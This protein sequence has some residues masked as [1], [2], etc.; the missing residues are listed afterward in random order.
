MLLRGK[1]L[2]HDWFHLSLSII[3]CFY[4]HS[5]VLVV[6]ILCLSYFKIKV[7]TTFS[8]SAHQSIL[9]TIILPNHSSDCVGTN[10]YL[11]NDYTH[12]LWDKF[13][14][15]QLV[16]ISVHWFFTLKHG[17]WLILSCI[18]AISSMSKFPQMGICQKK[19]LSKRS[20]FGGAG[21]GEIGKARQERQVENSTWY[22]FLQLGPA[23][24][25]G[26]WRENTVNTG[27]RNFSVSDLGHK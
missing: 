23:H 6:I 15:P 19:N 2:T 4:C 10:S 5:W 25:L 9:Y 13:Q 20:F 11:F 8:I 1:H 12:H 17:G 24:K 16:L 26:L 27:W 21:R 14:T 18:E 22:L 7:T 3:F